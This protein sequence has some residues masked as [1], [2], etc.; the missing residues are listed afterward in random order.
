[1]TASVWKLVGTLCVE[2]PVFVAALALVVVDGYSSSCA[3]RSLTDFRSC[4]ASVGCYS[5]LLL[6]TGGATL[7]YGT[8]E[9][10]ESCVF[11]HILGDSAAGDAGR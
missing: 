1:M 10:A 11:G 9:A 6:L 3:C 7:G 2:D 5:I 8:G 4:L